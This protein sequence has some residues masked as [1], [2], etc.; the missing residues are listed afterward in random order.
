MTTT[1]MSKRSMSS[2]PRVAMAVPATSS[3]TFRASQATTATF[4][5]TASAGTVSAAA[6]G[7]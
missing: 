2:R 6:S 7:E 5:S 1:P 3:A 4:V